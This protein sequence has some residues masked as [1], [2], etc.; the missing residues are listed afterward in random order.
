MRSCISIRTFTDILGLVIGYFLFL[1]RQLEEIFV[2][3]LAKCIHLRVDCKDT[4]CGARHTGK[5]REKG[6]YYQ[7][8]DK[9]SGSHDSNMRQAAEPYLNSCDIGYLASVDMI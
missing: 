9:V 1:V 7:I 6:E 3:F 4:H 8:S 2:K 5:N